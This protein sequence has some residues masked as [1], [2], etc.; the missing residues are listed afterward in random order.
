MM[1]SEP[2]MPSGKELA[3]LELLVGKQEMYGLEMVHASNKLG[4]GTI[5]VVLKRM[6]D[7]GFITSRQDKVEGASGIPKRIYKVTGYGQRAW[8]MWRA[9]QA[10]YEAAP[11]VARGW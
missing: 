6:E 9:A 5:Y 8:N 11:S 2:R 1:P 4:R 3:V 7:K 10:A